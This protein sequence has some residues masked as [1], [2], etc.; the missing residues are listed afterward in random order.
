M[1]H[2]EETYIVRV[3][4]HDGDAVVEDVRSRERSHVRELSDLGPLITRLLER[5]RS[6][7][8]EQRKREGPQ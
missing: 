6:R 2:S 7:R 1:P 3:R 5:A 8:P 4:R